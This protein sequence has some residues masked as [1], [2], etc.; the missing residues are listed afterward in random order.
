M[1]AIGM[2]DRTTDIAVEAA[3][4][5]VGKLTTATEVPVELQLA[6]EWLPVSYTH[7]TLPTK[8]IV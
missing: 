8:R 5:N 4:R 2:P 7:L 3:E 1:A 6:L